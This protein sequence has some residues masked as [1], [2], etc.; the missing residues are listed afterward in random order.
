M[1]PSLWTVSADGIRIVFGSRT[2]LTLLLFG[3]QSTRV[4]PRAVA[5]GLAGLVGLTAAAMLAVSWTQLHTSVAQ[6]RQ[7][8]AASS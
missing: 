6:A 3:W 2:L 5:V 4:R 1:R 8:G 7:P